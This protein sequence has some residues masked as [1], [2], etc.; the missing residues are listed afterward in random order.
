MSRNR[1]A[2][3]SRLRAGTTTPRHDVVTI[4]G[5]RIRIPDPERLVHL[6]FRRFAG[7]PVCN[8]HLQSVARRHDEI[9][10]AGVREVV[11][12]HSTVKELRKYE[13]GLPFAVVADP[14]KRLYVAFGV[15]SSRRALLHPRVW[16]PIIRAV[17]HSL[18]AIA[19][20]RPVPPLD[21]AGGRYGLP[22]DFL[23]GGDG[24]VLA[25]KYGEHADDQWSVDELL[26]HTRSVARGASGRAAAG[27]LAAAAASA[28]DAPDER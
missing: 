28:V 13:D 12:F 23:I 4:G 2:E 14:T 16:L 3:P 8:L 15:E 25:C 21:P 26:Q 18:G 6:Q 22:A 1:R 9:V 19:R 5:E 27:T 20:G 7:C 10:A 11:V 17:A 24:R